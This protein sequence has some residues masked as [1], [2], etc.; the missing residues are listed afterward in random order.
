MPLNLENLR[1][2]KFATR[3]PDETLDNFVKNAGEYFT[4]LDRDISK[5]NPIDAIDIIPAM[6]AFAEYFECESRW[7]QLT[8][9]ALDV[10]RKGISRSLIHEFASFSGMSH[11]GFAINDLANK[12]PKAQPFLQGI[13]KI[14]CNNLLKYMKKSDTVEFMTAANYEVI[15]GLSGPLSYLLSINEKNEQI[16]DLIEQIVNAFIRRSKDTTLLG[17][18]MTGWHYYPSKVE[19]AYMTEDAPNGIVNYGLS[20][21]MAGPLVTL[22]LA[23]K[24]GLRLNGLKGAINGL[25]A[26]FMRGL[27]HDEDNTVQ[28][29]GRITAEQYLGLEPKQQVP[30]QQSWCYGSVGILRSLYIVG[31]VM[32]DRQTEKFAIDEM[33]K[34]AEMPL[35]KYMLS[36]PIVCHG[37]AG[38]AAI[39]DIM[40]QDT[41]RREFL[42]KVTEMVEVSATY[43][44]EIFL[45]SEKKIANARSISS[46]ATL[47]EHL[48]GYNG[49]VQ[50]I[51]SILKGRPTG[52]EKRLLML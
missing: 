21:G 23:H 19:K 18:Q 31:V 45:E 51:F 26:E 35:E 37:L 8:L 11:V 39:L 22:A 16:T 41:G 1:S 20:H 52:H 2:E 44:T 33:V 42:T 12:F 6:A 25:V 14:L 9:H 34:I 47:H 49:I 5:I 4:A 17:Q 40:Y 32:G 28:W 48:E 46:R 10:L 7:Q 36:Q 38:T 50:T 29:P 30:R 27:Y 43:S 15:L 3:V 24:K 13:N